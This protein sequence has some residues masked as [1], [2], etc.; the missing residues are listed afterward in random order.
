MKLISILLISSLVYSCLG[1]FSTRVNSKNDEIR[2]SLENKKELSI[3]TRQLEKYSLYLPNTYNFK[4]DTVYGLLRSEQW[5]IRTYHT[6]KIPFNDIYR[7]EKKQINPLKT[8]LLFGGITAI[9]VAI[10]NIEIGFGMNFR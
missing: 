6:A 10:S 2:G 8:I 9:I 4:N 5:N 1:C 3:T 7:V